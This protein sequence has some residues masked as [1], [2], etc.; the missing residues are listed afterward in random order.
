[1]FRPCLMLLATLLAVPALA[2]EAPMPAGH[3]AMM[4]GHGAMAAGAKG[5]AQAELMRS[6][7]GM[8]KAM[9]APMSGNPD[10]DFVAMMIPHHQAAVEMAKVEL[11]YG[12]D[13]KILALAKAVIAA[14]EQEIA[15]MRDW[16]AKRAK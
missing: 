7:D 16:Q 3:G 1:M 12:K 15:E 10:A 4:S 11:R 9:A 2:D 8:N 5:P 13:P 14:Q 6:M